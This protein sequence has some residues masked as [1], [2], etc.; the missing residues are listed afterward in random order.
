MNDSTRSGIRLLTGFLLL[1]GG[2]ASPAWSDRHMLVLA[3]QSNMV[4]QALRA[5]QDLPDSFPKVQVFDLNG[6]WKNKWLTLR[7]GLGQD[8]SRFGVEITLATTL[9]DSI[10]QDTF[11]LVKAAESATSMFEYW[12]S[13]SPSG[14]A[15]S[16]Y[17]KMIE[18]VLGA[19]DSLR[20]ARPPIDG[21][22]WMQGESD[23]LFE[24]FADAYQVNFDAFVDD[25]RSDWGD[26]T[27]PIVVGLID[28][29]PVWP[30]ASVVREA[31]IL[32]CDAHP[33]MGKVETGGLETDG[34]H[35]TAKGLKELGRRMAAAWIELD[36]KRPK[37]IPTKVDRRT[38]ASP[39]GLADG[40]R[41]VRFRFVALDGRAESWQPA[42]TWRSV[43]GTRG[44]DPNV[45]LVQWIGEQGRI[46]TRRLPPGL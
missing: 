21:F 33:Y 45:K 5:G 18:G 42:G 31:Q 25:L 41:F 2:G 13:W 15:G 7:P 44:R 38:Y 36:R 1:L 34:V 10:P 30:Y 29:Q 40:S 28:K 32:T 27:L 12:H 26:S 24:E 4:G 39:P 11:Y 35:Y 3:G 46:E 9:V 23:A 6:E 22:F 17:S 8:T 14:E 43:L 20:G 19:R 16:L 37:P